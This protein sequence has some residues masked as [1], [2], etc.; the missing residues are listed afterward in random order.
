MVKYW[1]VRSWLLSE[2]AHCINTWQPQSLSKDYTFCEGSATRAIGEWEKQSLFKYLQWLRLY[3]ILGK[4]GLCYLI[5][6]SDF[7][8]HD[9]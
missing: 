8:L 4:I 3:R 9:A 7:G 5:Q 1:F 2:V 6:E